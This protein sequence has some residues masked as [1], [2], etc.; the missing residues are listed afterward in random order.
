M[1]RRLLTQCTALL[2]VVLAPLAARAHNQKYPVEGKTLNVKTTGAPKTYRFSFTSVRQLLIAADHNPATDGAALLVYGTGANAGTTGLIQLNP[3]FWKGV[4]TPPGSKAYKYVDASGSRGGVR[5]ITYMTG[6]KGGTLSITAVGPNWTWLPSGPQDT[7]AVHFRVENE[8]YCAEFNTFTKNQAGLVKA[9]NAAAPTSCPAVCGNGVVETGEECDDGDLNDADGCTTACV[10]TDCTGETFA[11]TWDALQTVVFEN[12]GCT[13]SLCH[14]NTA[15]PTGGLNL[16][17]EVAY[18]NLVSV[19]SQ[20]GSL[21]RVHPGD[22]DLSFLYLKLAAATLAPNGPSVPGTPMP[23][24]GLPPISSDSLTALKL[25]IRAGAPE[26]GVVED[27]AGLLE[28]C[29]PPTSPQKIPPLDP[30]A[31]GSGVQLY[32]PPWDLPAHSENEVCYSTYYDFSLT[33]GVVPASAQAP[34]PDHLGGPSQTCFRYQET[35]LAQDPQSHHSIIHI[36][37]G[38]YDTNDPGWGTWTCKGGAKDGMACNPKGIGTAAPAGADCG[39]RAGCT[40]TV[41]PAVGCVLYGPPDYGFNNNN[42]PT[43]G[44]SQEPLTQQAYPTGVYSMLPMKGIVVFNSHAFNLT[45]T[46]TTM[47]QYYNL[48]FAGASHESYQVQGIFDS[49]EIFVQNVPAFESRE[50]CRTFTLPQNARVFELSSH[51]HKRGKLFRIWAPPNA[52]CTAAG[53]CQPNTGVPIYIS[54]TYNDPVRLAFDPPVHLSSGSA[55][56]R[57]YK[58]CARY[59]NG[60]SNPSEVKRRSTSP[61]PANIFAPGGPCPVAETRCLGGPNQ[62]QLCSGDHTVCESSPGAGDG[63]CDACP[64]RGGVTTEDEMLIALGSYYVA[65]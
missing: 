53:G 41:T 26:T 13:N 20:I 11:S 32:A 47:E 64:L 19:P 7:V 42:A 50:Y 18:E 56:D 15:A 59:D 25:W 6:G 33:P 39:P 51:T 38:A 63:V 1:R 65:P 48:L 62:G 61:A 43:F 55:A 14:G 10:A 3:S 5:K 60:A 22:Q 17:P 49:T 21:L 37:R 16:L 40:G 9:R 27:T 46:D 30:P 12:G 23:A 4:G 35:E 58:F 52:S 45:G 24:G 54:T 31:A 34:C 28:T 29:L 36:Y 2:V 57:T 44:G 8:W